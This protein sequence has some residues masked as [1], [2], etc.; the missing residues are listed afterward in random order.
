MSLSLPARS[1][2][3]A[4]PDDAFDRIAGLVRRVIGV[5]VALVSLVDVT[6][7]VFPGAAGLP[8]PWAGTRQTPL[9]H[10]F[11]QHVVR[12]GEPLVIT[13]ARRD[14]RLHDNLAIGDIGV[15]AYAGYPLTLHDGAV[16]GSLCA[17]DN[18]P[19]AWS[20][21][22]LDLL[23]DLAEACAAELRLREAAAVAERA[24][25]RA[26]VL[27]EFAETLAATE[28]LVEV[29]AAVS[30][31][32]TSRLG[33]F[34]GG[35]TVVD[36]DGRSIRYV[37]VS[38]LPTEM[39]GSYR[40]SPMSR[41]APSPYVART[42][43]PLFFGSLAE[44]R[45]RF[46][47][48]ADD[49]AA[50]GVG[51]SAFQPIRL[52]GPALGN[53]T[54]LWR[55]DRSFDAEDRELLTGLGRYAAQ[56]VVRARL[57]AD[58]IA[59]AETLQGAMLPTLPDVSWL[60]LSGRYL[61]ARATD[62]V[63]GD[64]FDAVPRPDGSVVLSVGD[65]EGHDTT[66]AA[67]MGQL[68]SLLRGLTF[69]SPGDPATAL[70]ALD[71]LLAIFPPERYA[72]C[73]LGTL[74]RAAENAVTSDVTLQWTNAGHPPPVLLREGQPPQLWEVAAQLPIGMPFRRERVC[75]ELTL[76]PGT[77]LLFYSDGLVEQPGVDLHE[78]LA[79]LCD[80]VA[81]HR[82]LPLPE[83]ADAVLADLVDARHVDDVL[84]LGV[85]VR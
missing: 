9:S 8:Q 19:R 83:L 76:S 30:R 3:P 11:C 46:P 68:R 42:G 81:R 14:P 65:V 57:L 84:L 75:H 13:D 15:I 61:P 1:L 22:E 2:M 56:A 39:R 40:T 37:D 63:G 27:L 62:A 26:G 5:P 47:Q 51:G 45:D 78:A 85:R 24:R 71:D 80:V 70:T 73:V 6:R 74:R 72:T 43:E 53:L 29:G 67:V 28:T 33:A 17:I 59:V 41:D 48:A 25:E 60:E 7:Q 82:A 55:E 12:S 52:A 44:L 38:A 21:H 34:F 50:A 77:V 32:A 58:R 35:I 18:E 36:P 31:L 16:V 4:E 54:L 66:A 79:G 20:R 64:W 23:A 49:I 69:A 10:S